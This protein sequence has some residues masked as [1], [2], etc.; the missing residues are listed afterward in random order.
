MAAPIGRLGLRGAD[1]DHPRRGRRAGAGERAVCLMLLSDQLDL[2]N[3][4]M[5]ETDR[6]IRASAR[7]TEVGRRLMDVPGVGPLLASALVATVPDPHA[8]R[9]AATW[10]PGS[11]SCRSR[12][13]AA[14][15]SG[16]AGSPSRAIA[17]CGQMLVVGALAVIRY[18]ERHGTRAALARAA[19]GAANHQGR[20]RRAR[21]QDRPDGLGDHDQRR[22][23]SGAGAAGRIEIRRPL[24]RTSLGRATK[25]VM[26]SAGRTGRREN[27][28]APERLRARAFGRDPLRGGHY[29]QRPWRR[30]NRS[31]TWPHRPSLQKLQKSLANGEPSTHGAPR[32]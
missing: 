22:A 10:R 9:S 25:D 4:Q 18:A 7:A 8:F 3:G 28:L 15:R 20:R 31:N 26:R 14:A 24:R 27:P 5:L 29:G 23:L 13:P 17:T 21:Q 32:K 30:T 2:V 6:R 12:T 19:D 1:R 11:G 16:W